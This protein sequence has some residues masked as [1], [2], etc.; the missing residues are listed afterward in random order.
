MLNFRS[1]Y[2][3]F[4]NQSLKW[5]S[6]DTE[7][8]YQKNLKYRYNELKNTGLIDN[9]FTY[10]FNSHGFRSPEFTTDSTV[11][12]LGCSNTMG[13]GM[14]N[15]LIWPTLVSQKLNMRSANLGIG[16]SGPDTAFRMCLGYIDKINPKIVVHMVNPGIRF[17]LV[18]EKTINLV[19]AYS[20]IQVKLYEQLLVDDNNYFFNLQ[21]NTLAIRML[22]AERKIKFFQ[23]PAYCI[24]VGG[25]GMHLGRDLEHPGI[26]KHKIVAEKIIDNL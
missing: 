11:M 7:Q 25:W 19:N 15:D 1:R 5:L 12:F 22:C 18:D 8:L 14:P 17:E 4:A 9:N 10:D 13:V 2:H 24:F 20:N 23:I 3:E 21:K 6:T 26:H 16:G